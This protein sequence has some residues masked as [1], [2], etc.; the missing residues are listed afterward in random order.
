MQEFLTF[1]L[2][3]AQNQPD[4]LNLM[5]EFNHFFNYNFDRK[6]T[7]KLL[8]TFTEKPELGRIYLINSQG[9]PIGYIVLSF[10][11]SF[12]YNGRDAFIDEFYLSEDYRGKGIGKKAIDFISKKAKELNVNALHLET[13]PENEIAKNL[14]L[15]RGFK[16]NNRI[17]LTKPISGS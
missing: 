10:G 6:K 4:I 1:E 2:V 5:S 11:F 15:A 9:K 14:Y 12:E 13:E 16:T 3:K 7:E 17:L 8:I